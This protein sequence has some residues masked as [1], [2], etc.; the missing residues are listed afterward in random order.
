MRCA[1]GT[2]KEERSRAQLVKATSVK[3]QH[4]N[5]FHSTTLGMM[6]YTNVQWGVGGRL[7]GLDAQGRVVEIKN[8]TRRFFTVIPE[9][10]R[11]QVACYLKIMRATKALLVQ[12]YN[13]EQRVTEIDDEGPRWSL[14]LSL[15][16][17]VVT[18]L[19][20]FVADD[21]VALRHAWVTC[22]G[23]EDKQALLTQW[24]A[25][26]QQVDKQLE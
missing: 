24:L 26:Q 5:K 13:G 25:E 22:Y 17:A 14:Y 10:E 19:D 1:Y 18:M 6:P 15:M 7:D 16:T 23:G 12:Q 21:S 20:L 9:Y 8:R 3:V 4:T 2:A 11:V